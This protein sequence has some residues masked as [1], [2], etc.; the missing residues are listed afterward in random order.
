[1]EIPSVEYQTRVAQFDYYPAPPLDVQ[2]SGVEYREGVAIRDL[3]YAGVVSGRV[4]AL[5]VAPPGDGTCPGV[6]F[7][8][9]APGNRHTFLDEAIQLAQCGAVSLLIDAPWSQGEAWGRTMGEPEHDRREHIQTTQNLRRAIDLLTARPEVDVERLA[10]VGHSLGALFGGILIGVEARLKTC[11][12]MAG[13]GSFTDVAAWNLPQL[14]GPVLEHYRQVLAPIDPLYYVRFAAPAPLLF[15]FGLQDRSFARAKFIEFA[16]AGS[17]PK[18]VK[19]YHT[20]HYLP[21]PGARRDRLE[22]LRG[23][24]NLDRRSQAQ[25]Q[26]QARYATPRR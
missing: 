16:A 14:R 12:L 25:V 13:V 21:D 19:W 20:D 10:Y 24:L 11:V 4:E 22:W 3:S 9:P 1:M 6:I 17:E 23:H 2:E 7:V 8:H 5:L 26:T 15:Q 18:A